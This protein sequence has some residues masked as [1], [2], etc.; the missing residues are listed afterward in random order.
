VEFIPG[1]VQT[2]DGGSFGGF[3]P[4]GWSFVRMLIIVSSS[5]FGSATA[6]ASASR[7]RLLR[8]APGSPA[9]HFTMACR[10]ARLLWSRGGRCL[11][12]FFH[13]AAS[14]IGHGVG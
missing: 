10:T 3:V 7:I 4:V 5:I 13:K 14:H 6:R 12:S 2:P 8:A 9:R 11:C 1:D